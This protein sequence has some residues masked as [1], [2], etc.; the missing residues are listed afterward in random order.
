MFQR[1]FNLNPSVFIDASVDIQCVENAYF[2]IGTSSFI[3]KDTFIQLTYPHPKLIIG[4]GCVIGRN[5][6]LNAKNLISIGDNT[7][8]GP[9]V[10][11]MDHGHS[12]KKNIL[13]K[14]Q[15]AII[16]ETHIGNDC[17]LGSGAR[18]LKG[19]VLGNGV[20]V[21][22]NAVVTKNFSDNAVIAGVPAR[23]IRYRDEL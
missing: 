9:F 14:E 16:E 15:K 21:G 5:C 17:W 10:Q 1:L 11:I 8:I 12:F 6:I 19:V 3:L 18:I 2:E 23:L 22:A 4:S 7:L 20:V 13:I